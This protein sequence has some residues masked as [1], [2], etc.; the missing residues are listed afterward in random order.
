L[1][2][3][4]RRFLWLAGAATLVV[5]LDAQKPEPAEPAWQLLFD[6]K[7]LGKWKPTA[8]GGEGDVIVADGQIVLETGS[9]LTGITWTGEVPKEPYEIE[10]KAAR[11][12]GG[13][14]FCGLTFPVRD[15]HCSLIVGGWAGA[16]VGLS[17]LDGADASENETTRIRN[18]EDKRWYTVRVRVT[19]D[20]IQA[21]IDDEA[22]VDVKIA[23]RRIG[24]RPE[25]ALS[26]PLGIASWRTR[27]GLRDIRVRTVSQSM[28]AKRG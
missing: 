9:D 2:P 10:V 1:A 3:G 13:D 8:F 14:F 16:V 23:G 21:W 26:R 4:R 19:A 20:R 6:G 7:T 28:A 22:F 11:L 5:V 27:A 24:I 15:T 18:F 25:V 12:G 17:S